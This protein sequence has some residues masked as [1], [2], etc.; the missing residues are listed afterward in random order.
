[1][2]QRDS[3]CVSRRWLC[4]IVIASVPVEDIRCTI[5]I[6]SGQVEDGS[7]PKGGPVGQ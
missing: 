6:A 4:K 1:M 2:Y 7:V 3:Q 5:G